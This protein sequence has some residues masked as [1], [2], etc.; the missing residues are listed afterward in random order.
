MV[1]G[2]K[3]GLHPERLKKQR[4]QGSSEAKLPDHASHFATWPPPKGD[5][6]QLVNHYKKLKM[7]K[8]G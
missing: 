2:N 7:D 8:M 4:G 1:S 5:T 6:R 3:T